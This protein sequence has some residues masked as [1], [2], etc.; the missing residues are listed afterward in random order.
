MNH[1]KS[2]DDR[3]SKK[4][5]ESIFA[6]GGIPQGIFIS[7]IMIITLSMPKYRETIKQH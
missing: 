2:V 3:E 4:G 5:C 1:T 7:I 6:R